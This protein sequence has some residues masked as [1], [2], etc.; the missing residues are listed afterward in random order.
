MNSNIKKYFLP[1]NNIPFQN[2]K[3]LENFDYQF[4]ECKEIRI[5]D[6]F[7]EGAAIITVYNSFHRDSNDHLTKNSKILFGPLLSQ[8]LSTRGK[9]KCI[10]K[11]K[12]EE[13]VK[14]DDL[15]HLKF[16]TGSGNYFVTDSGKYAGMYGKKT[17]LEKVIHLE[18]IHIYADWLLKLRVVIELLKKNV[19]T[20]LI[21]LTTT[22]YKE[23]AHLVLRHEP[24]LSKCSD[25]VF[26][27]A[28]NN[29]IPSMLEM[30]LIEDIPEKY[31]G[32]IME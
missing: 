10:L 23:I 26:E 8:H 9:L 15:P 18:G 20:G 22:E 25:D 24:S 3:S 13:N 6:L 12:L 29:W 14:I 30:P 16:K 19:K 32:K 11:E 17:E 1:L 21:N 2:I 28:V 4:I 5:D 27:D 31:I 7:I